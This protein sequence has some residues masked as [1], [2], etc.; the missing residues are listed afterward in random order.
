M[1]GAGPP[2]KPAMAR[3]MGWDA[4]HQLLE[5]SCRLTASRPLCLAEAPSARR[6]RWLAAWSW[7]AFLQGRTRSRGAGDALGSVHGHTDGQAAPARAAVTLLPGQVLIHVPPESS[8]R[9]SWWWVSLVVTGL[10]PDRPRRRPL[11][12]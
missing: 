12:C 1:A 11:F 10:L 3:R 8:L 9:G 6:A 4:A 5:S 2:G 7:Q